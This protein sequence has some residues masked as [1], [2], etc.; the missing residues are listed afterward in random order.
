MISGEMGQG[1]AGNGNGNGPPYQPY[2]NHLLHTSGGVVIKRNVLS[3]SLVDINDPGKYIKMTLTLCMNLTVILTKFL[4]FSVAL[5]QERL[6][7]RGSVGS[8]DSGMSV[9]FHHSTSTR[10]L[11]IPQQQQQQPQPAPSPASALCHKTVPFAAHGPHAVFRQGSTASNQGK[12]QSTSN[13][14]GVVLSGNS[15][16]R[17]RRERGGSMGGQEG[18]AG[19]TTEV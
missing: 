9:S 18:K 4:F 14:L 7:R 15:N 6:Q 19:K 8:L 12:S 3:N 5:A 11:H 13:F 2:Q 10:A 1:P 16:S 17:N